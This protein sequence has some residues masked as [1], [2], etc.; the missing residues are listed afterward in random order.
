MVVVHFF[1]N[2]DVL[3]TQLLIEAPSEGED[4]TIKGR[5]GKVSKVESIDDKTIH[6]Q[7]LIEK[8]TIKNQFVDQ[9]K[10]KRR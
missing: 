5:K 3:L 7:V 2:K 1:E 10:K 9:S 4:V 8:I 6:V